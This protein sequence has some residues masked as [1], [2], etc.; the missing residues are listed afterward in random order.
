[1]TDS[2]T[3]RMH[4]PS[5]PSEMSPSNMGP[6]AINPDRVWTLKELDIL[7]DMAK[8]VAILV[9]GAYEDPHWYL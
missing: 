2:T 7:H 1:M 9:G 3:A 5:V 4:S 6:E 8:P